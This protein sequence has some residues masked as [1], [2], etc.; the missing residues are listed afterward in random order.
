M[1]IPMVESS[2]K[3]IWDIVLL[4][5]LYYLGSSTYLELYA[6]T[7]LSSDSECTEN[8]PYGEGSL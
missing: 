2:I 6:Y 8:L 1:S 5:Y 3:V 7:G 4:V